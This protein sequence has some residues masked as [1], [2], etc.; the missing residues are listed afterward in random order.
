MSLSSQ[1][2]KP[3]APPA[4]AAAPSADGAVLPVISVR[5][6]DVAPAAA[7][8]AD[9]GFFGQLMSKIDSSLES[10]GFSGGRYIVVGF[11]LLMLTLLFFTRQWHRA[12]VHLVEVEKTVVTLN[13]QL[14]SLMASQEE[15]LKILREHQNSGFCSKRM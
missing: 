4:A 3:K 2:L 1:H 15:M 9:A 6:V 5:A 8:N 10:I 13:E 14:K 12:H 11:L 7:P